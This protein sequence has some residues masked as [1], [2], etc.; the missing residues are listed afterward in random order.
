MA[1]VLL[2]NPAYYAD[3]FAGSNVRAAVSPGTPPLGLAC[4]AAG[5]LKAG[6]EVKLLDLNVSDDPERALE[7]AVRDFA[8]QY[9]GI[10]STTP[11]I[12]K[13]YAIA[14]KLKAL[15][16]GIYVLAGGPHPSALPEDVLRESRIDCVVRGEGDFVFGRV[17]EEGPNPEIPNIFYKQAGGITAAK[18]Q[19]ALSE[20]LD[21]LPFPAY[22]LLDSSKYHQP[23]LAARKSPLAYMETSRGCYARCV[24]C[25]KNICGF[26]LRMK[27]PSRVVDEMEH[28]LGLGY[29]EIHIIDDIFTADMARAEAVCAEIMKRGLVFPWYPR[30]GIRVDRVNPGLLAAMKNAGCY[31]IPF[32]VESGSQRVIDVVNKKITLEQAERAVKMAKEAGLET[33]CYFMLALP[34]ETEEDMRKSIAF[35]VKLDPDYAKFAVTIPLPGTPMFDK[36]LSEGRLKTFDWSKYNFST[37]PHELF[38]HDVLTPETIDR[39]RRLAYRKFYFRPGFAA[40]T[41]ARTLKDGTFLYH[42]KAFFQTRWS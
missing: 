17:I 20:N 23:R 4:V 42:V 26:R 31:R 29:K 5:L 1:K 28:L 2:I 34:T 19:G 7:T 6:H 33:E 9:A 15:N 18:T 11:L 36:M 8:P 3:I 32:G 12:K 38:S 25:N 22:T 41:L 24:F 16:H 13:A 27:S 21:A 39:Y 35:A 10:T 37:P 14:A 40:R 30:G